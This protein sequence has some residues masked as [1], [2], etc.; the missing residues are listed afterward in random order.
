MSSPPAFKLL[1]ESLGL[2]VAKAAVLLGL[3]HSS[4][5]K[6]ATGERNAPA[7]VIRRCESLWIEIE[8][9]AQALRDNPALVPQ[10]RVAPWLRKA[11]LRRI[12][13]INI[14][15]AHDKPP[16]TDKAAAGRKVM[17]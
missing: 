16:A 2:S 1:T 3:D 12:H 8:R 11:V 15:R 9:A 10:A 7:D 5:Q 4:A 17:L 13:E 14:V 6:Y